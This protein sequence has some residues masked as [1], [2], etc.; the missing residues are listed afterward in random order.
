MITPLILSALAAFGAVVDDD[1]EIE[2]KYLKIGAHP[3]EGGILEMFSLLAAP[4]NLAGPGGLLEEGFGVHSPYIPNRRT[5]AT[6]EVLD[7][8]ADYPVLHYSYDCEGPNISGLHVTRKME[9]HPEES[10]VKVSWTVENR[11]KERQ[12]VS[13]W[14]RCDVSAG[15]AVDAGD[16]LEF[17]S[18]KGKVDK[19]GRNYYAAARN[20]AAITDPAAQLT[21]FA[22]FNPE[23]LHSI[24]AFRGPDTESA[25]QAHFVPVVLQPGKSWSTVYRV[26]AV[27]GLSH[28]DFATDEMAMQL[29]A[30][31]DKLTALMASTKPLPEL[32]IH[33]SVLAKNQR[34]WKLDPKKFDILPGKLVRATFDWQAPE[35][36]AYEFL[37]ELRKG[38][39][40]AP[41]GK[42]TGSPHGGV[43]TQ[44]VAGGGTSKA[45][46]AALEPWTAAPFALDQQPRLLDRA[47]ISDGKVRVWREPS[48]HKVLQTDVPNAAGT[49]AAITLRLAKGE[50]EAFQLAF[51]AQPGQ[52]IFDISVGVSGLDNLSPKVRNVDYVD[53]RVPS[54]YEGA[55]GKWPDILRPFKAFAATAN[56]TLPVWVDVTAP[57]DIA[58]GT[59]TGTVSISGSAL[60][61]ITVPL[62]VEVYDFALPERPSLRTDFG[63]D[64]DAAAQLH[65]KHGGGLSREQLTQAFAATGLEHR[66]TLRGVTQLPA[67]SGDY[68]AALNRFEQQLG[69][70]LMNAATSFSVP[71]TLA[72]QPDSLKRAQM[73]LSGKK[74]SDRAFVQLAD[75]PEQITWEQLLDGLHTWHAMAPD[76]KTRVST[77]GMTPFLALDLDTW[78]VHAQVMD[79]TNGQEVLKRIAENKPVWWYV[80]HQPSRP[81]ANLLLDFAAIEHRIL[82]WQTWALGMQGVYYWDVQYVE[83][84]TDPFVSQLDITPCN[85]DGFLLYPGKQGVLDSVRWE[86]IRDGIEDVDYLTLFTQ[87]RKDLEKKN[88]ASPLLQKARAAGN[89]EK[90][91]PSLVS[92]T[93]NIKDLEAKRD[94]LARLI[95]EMQQN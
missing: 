52:E 48:L 86:I 92:Y 9:L 10:S 61:A 88:P 50:T 90:I 39:Q 1:V 54:H 26:S 71:A 46:S 47:M 83:P 56:K 82:F 69:A 41:L 19:P 30:Q 85:G 28:V 74:L 21:C 91:I 75:E 16:K 44:F 79:S 58:A 60:D 59:Y 14:V 27:H 62:N 57:A 34:T 11:G 32:E 23:H 77:G 15:P 12:W 18:L 40:P 29:D 22:V 87:L 66:V 80:N 31:G 38:G 55:T 13:P 76:I 5:N 35:P 24:L 67:P 33:A 63:L 72:D 81:Y 68:T 4:D 89:L 49:E 64:M 78:V 93:R 8:V 51:R 20:W 84:G 25:F 42:D 73:W 36:G 65:R 53:A 2:S 45:A 7:A 70:R 43:D 37:A 17:M 94:E 95:V 6:M 3:A